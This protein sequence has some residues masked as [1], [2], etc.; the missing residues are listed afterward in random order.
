M[1]AWRWET[2]AAAT[3]VAEGPER[4]G[5]AVA[6]QWEEW[7]GPAV[8]AT[9]VRYSMLISACEKGELWHPALALLS[10]MLVAKLVST[11]IRSY[12][13]PTCACEKYPLKNSGG[14]GIG[15]ICDKGGR[16]QP[17]LALLNEM[18]AAILEPNLSCEK[19]GQ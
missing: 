2:A 19:G 15:F 6:A 7:G 3:A 1:A 11:P 10:E 8:A 16:R 17:A 12:S 5:T 9:A 4:G 18:L 14:S 13:A